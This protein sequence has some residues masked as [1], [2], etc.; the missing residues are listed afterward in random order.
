VLKFSRD[1]LLEYSRQM[2]KLMH[3]LFGLLSEALGLNSSYLEDIDCNQGQL[4]ICHYYP[5]CPKPELAIGTAAHSDSGFLTVLLQ[6]DVGGLQVLYKDRWIEV[7]P[8]PGAF[9]VNVGDLLQVCL[10]I[11]IKIVHK[12]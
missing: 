2:K 5:P 10:G 1:V 3:T 8:M 6:D 4:I 12:G 9:I 11:Q 7:K